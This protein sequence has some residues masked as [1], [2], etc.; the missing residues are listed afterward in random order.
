M[1]RNWALRIPLAVVVSWFATLEFRMQFNLPALR[2]LASQRDDDMYD[3]VGLNAALLVMGWLPPLIVTLVMVVVLQLVL[4]MMRRT[5][6]DT[7]H[8]GDAES[9]AAP[10]N[11]T[12]PYREPK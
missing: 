1:K 8:D 3:G 5:A 7:H 9:S 6:R 12:Q 4:A 2:E 11:A 10:I